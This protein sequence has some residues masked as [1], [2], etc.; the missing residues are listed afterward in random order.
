[1]KLDAIANRHWWRPTSTVQ[2]VWLVT[3]VWI[4]VIALFD[5]LGPP[6][7]FN[8]DWTSRWNTDHFPRT[9]PAVSALAY[10]QVA[11]AYLVTFGHHDP[12]L[13]RLS[14]LAFVILAV[15]G[16]YRLARLLGTDPIWSAVAALSLVAFPVFAV[17]ATT[18]MTDVPYVGIEIWALVAAIRWLQG[19]RSPLPFVALVVVATLQ[20]QIGVLLPLG[21]ALG[22]LVAGPRRLNHFAWL[23]AATAAAAAAVAVVS[24]TG[25]LPPTNS[26]RLTE[27]SAR[28][29]LFVLIGFM[30][31]PGVVGLSLIALLPGLAR[32]VPAG[33]RSL[34]PIALAVVAWEVFVALTAGWDVLPGN[35]FMPR[36][37]NWTWRP[38]LKPA[39]YPAPLFALV[40]IAAVVGIAAFVTRLRTALPAGSRLAAVVLAG[41]AVTQFAPVLLLNYQVY[42]RYY[43]P[44]AAALLPL[45]AR[46]TSGASA[47]RAHVSIAM[48]AALLCLYAVGEQDYMASQVARDR[49]ARLAYQAASPYEVDAGYE[50]NAVYGEVPAY[51]QRGVILSGLAEQ[52]AHDFSLN[53]P[54]HPRLRLEI[55]PASDPR[56][57]VTYWS[58]APGK[59][60][61]VQVG[62]G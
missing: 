5:V 34:G 61:I 25:Q 42:D 8:D 12:R 29:S 23:A 44:V 41:V 13:L 45:A 6:L 30:F 48:A 24:L 3:S 9:Y 22:F 47:R 55:A 51:D 60:V 32:R 57:G 53:G 38:Y 52:G 37:L 1:M 28:S 46:A 36:A 21:V 27:V 19:G 18:F 26:N 50:A 62:G 54:D 7:S 49:A 15:A 35:V 11:W 20:R 33:V 40:E 43:L 56:P 4:L 16:T 17:D 2:M 14:A 59:V 31:L 58:L 10:P 39:I